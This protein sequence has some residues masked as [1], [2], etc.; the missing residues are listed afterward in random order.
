MARADRRSAQRA[1]RAAVSS[2]GIRASGQAGAVEQTLFFARLRK[3]AKWVFLGL[4]LVFALSFVVF[5]VGAG[6][7]GIGDILRGGGSTGS[8]PS[9]DAAQKR[10][11]EHPKDPAALRALATALQN[12]GRA[13]EAIPILEQRMKIPNQTET[14]RQELELAKQQAKES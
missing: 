2:R 1:S 8:G 14:V 3:N 5:G 13:D 9:V 6:G 7:T 12:D 4:A 10:V 11:D